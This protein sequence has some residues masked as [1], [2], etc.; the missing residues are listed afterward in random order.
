MKKLVKLFPLTICFFL[1]MSSCDHCKDDPEPEP[2]CNEFPATCEGCG[3]IG[4]IICNGNV[5]VDPYEGDTAGKKLIGPSTHK[6]TVRAGELVQCT[7]QVVDALKFN[8]KQPN[9]ATPNKRVIYPGALLKGNSIGDDTPELLAVERAGGHFSVDQ[10][11]IHSVRVDSVALHTVRDAWTDLLAQYQGQPTAAKFQVKI[12]EVHSN[13]ELYWMLG[14]SFENSFLSADGQFQ[15][16]SDESLHRVLVTLTQEY[17]TMNFTDPGGELGFFNKNNLPLVKQQLA[18]AGI[19]PGNPAVY[20]SSV[21]YGR[22]FYMLYESTTNSK[23]MKA[24]LDADF[25]NAAYS[26]EIE[27]EFH[28]F[29]SMSNLTINVLA[30]GGNTDTTFTAIG[31]KNPEQIIQIL[32]RASDIRT[33]VPISYELANVKNNSLV[34][35]GIFTQFKDKDCTFRSIDDPTIYPNPIYRFDLLGGH[36]SVK[37]GYQNEW[38]M[39]TEWY[40]AWNAFLDERTDARYQGVC[41]LGVNIGGLPNGS[42]YVGACSE[43]GCGLDVN[44]T[45]FRNTDFTVFAVARTNG[46]A[47]ANPSGYFFYGINESDAN[48]N[49]KL[50]FDGNDNVVFQMGGDGCTNCNGRLVGNIPSAF[51]DFRLF[52]FRFSQSEGMSIFENGFQI[53]IDASATSPLGNFSGAIIGAQGIPCANEKIELLEIR[54]WGY[55]FP[56]DKREIIEEELMRV[57]QL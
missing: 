39:V 12:E 44:G 18:A 30:Y 9:F 51:G 56:P 34:K 41:F 43:Q 24:F 31:K 26:A 10:L 16:S 33:G 54:A 7:E 27:S 20:V 3:E 15:F 22:Y 21:T 57:Y 5:Y 1:M 11:G 52:T 46:N 13:E 53:A 38:S 36:S 50:G 23:E 47:G 48:L 42:W 4:Q 8:E 37:L 19:G 14:I 28:S 55:A 6:D 40:N 32:G 2:S 29:D 45:G 35:V 25:G 17:Y 49:L